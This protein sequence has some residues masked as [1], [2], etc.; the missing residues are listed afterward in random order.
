MHKKNRAKGKNE[1]GTSQQHFP[2][3]LCGRT[4]IDRRVLRLHTENVHNKLK[5]FVCSFCE[6]AASSRSSLRMHIRQHTGIT[7]F[8]SEC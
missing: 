7:L 4:F 5:L 3:V 8:C 2:C 1:D 6:H